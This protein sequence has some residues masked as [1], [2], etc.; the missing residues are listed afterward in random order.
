VALSASGLVAGRFPVE[1]V[2]FFAAIWRAVAA[3]AGVCVPG[4]ATVNLQV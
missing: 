2:R 3:Q 4:V 1:L